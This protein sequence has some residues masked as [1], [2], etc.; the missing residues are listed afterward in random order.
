[1][2]TQPDR[3][4][5]PFISTVTVNNNSNN[6]GGGGN[7]GGGGGHSGGDVYYYSDRPSRRYGVYDDAWYGW[8]YPP[9]P[10]V[11]YDAPYNY[12]ATCDDG[13]SPWLSQR[14]LPPCRETA[15]PLADT[16]TADERYAVRQLLIQH[17]QEQQQQQQQQQQQHVH[18]EQRLMSPAMA[19]AAGAAAVLVFVAIGVIAARS[20]K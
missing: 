4:T 6:G 18:Q 9:P 16:T 3:K 5:E 12:Y 19:G 17:Q 7:S 14:S 2:P 1:M 20:I 10:P 13:R 8:R 11:Y 15:S